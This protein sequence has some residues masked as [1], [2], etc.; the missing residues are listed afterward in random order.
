MPATILRINC[1]GLYVARTSDV[2]RYHGIIIFHGPWCPYKYIKCVRVMQGYFP[3]YT[4]LKTVRVDRNDTIGK[5]V[6]DIVS[7][8]LPDLLLSKY[9]NPT[10]AL[11]IFMKPGCARSS[12]GFPAPP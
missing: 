3:L 2:V 7:E 5:N 4:F 11:T 1:G 6:D 12:F 8:D 10:K 9:C